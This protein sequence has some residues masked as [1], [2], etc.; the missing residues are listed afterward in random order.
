VPILP[1]NNSIL[2]LRI[3]TWIFP[4]NSLFLQVFTKFI[5]KILS[6]SIRP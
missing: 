4:S 5:W 1:F 3:I 6:P 2:L